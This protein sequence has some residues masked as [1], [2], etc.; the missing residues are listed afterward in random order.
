M[1]TISPI[2]EVIF[3]KSEILHNKWPEMF[4]VL[5]RHIYQLNSK[6]LYEKW[7]ESDIFCFSSYTLSC[8]N[9]YFILL[10]NISLE[11]IHSSSNSFGN[12]WICTLF[13]MCNINERQEHTHMN[14]SVNWFIDR[15]SPSVDHK[16]VWYSWT[17]FSFRFRTGWKMSVIAW[18][19]MALLWPIYR[20]FLQVV[21]SN[22]IWNNSTSH[23]GFLIF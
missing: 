6:S 19:Q 22:K 23:R 10:W 5:A 20:S 3:Q 8:L 2:L 16:S 4:S 12:L 13:R 21:Y 18:S 14:K 7:S 17:Y 15:Q 11:I 1:Q 9:F